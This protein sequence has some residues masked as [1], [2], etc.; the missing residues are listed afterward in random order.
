MVRS[1]ERARPGE[2]GMEYHFD[3]SSNG[4][5]GMGRQLMY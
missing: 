3:A 1:C 4:I 5:P 2:R